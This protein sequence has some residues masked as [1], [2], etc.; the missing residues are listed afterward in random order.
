MSDLIKVVDLTSFFRRIQQ[1]TG[2]LTMNALDDSERAVVENLAER[3]RAAICSGYVVP[4]GPA[5]NYVLAN[6]LVLPKLPELKAPE[7]SV[8]SAG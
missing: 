3:R 5:V 6:D 8:G 4:T 7:P 2:M 1:T